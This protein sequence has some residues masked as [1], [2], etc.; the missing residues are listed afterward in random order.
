MEIVRD[1]REIRSKLL[2]RRRAGTSRLRGFVPTMGYLHRGHESLIERAREYNAEVCVSLFVNPTQFNQA[3]DFEN[4]PRETERDLEILERYQ[5]E[6]VLIPHQD[7]IYGEGFQTYIEPGDLG[8]RLEGTHRPGH[9]RGVLTVVNILF[10]LVDPDLAVFGEKDF[11]QLR[12]IEQMVTDLKIPIEIIRAPLI[13][14]D[15]G[16][17]LSSRNV[18]LSAAGRSRALSISKG[19]Q[20]ART[21]ALAGERSSRKLVEVA[22]AA[23]RS[24]PELE[25]EYLEIADEQR[26]QPVEQLSDEPARML[27]AVWSDGVRLIDNIALY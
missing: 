4:Y 14:E 10:Q 11:Q 21:K 27:A 13:R 3:S 2:G 18:R 1:L 15:D 22:T 9:F 7:T 5:V 20:I 26:L 23:I 25:I 19:L 6:Y 12:L 16:L 24:H 17:A 8:T